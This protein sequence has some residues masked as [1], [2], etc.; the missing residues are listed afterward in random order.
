[1]CST[2]WSGW[3][4]RGLRSSCGFG[5]CVMLSSESESENRLPLVLVGVHPDR[6]GADCR[7]ARGGWGGGGELGECVVFGWWGGAFGSRCVWVGRWRR[8]RALWCSLVSVSPCRVGVGE[9][10][11]HPPL[12]SQLVVAIHRSDLPRPP[13]IHTLPPRVAKPWW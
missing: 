5:W 6:A 3:C 13:G 7:G 10:R 11:F 9:V 2:P 12:A 8:I 1:M 4:S